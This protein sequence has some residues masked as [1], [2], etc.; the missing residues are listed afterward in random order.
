MTAKQSL[1]CVFQ[2][3]KKPSLP[4]ESIA[5]IGFPLNM[6]ETSST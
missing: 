2:T 3:L 1:V 6:I 4:V 5:V